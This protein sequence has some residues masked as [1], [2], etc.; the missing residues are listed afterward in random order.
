M[1]LPLVGG[2]RSVGMDGTVILVPLQG[3]R[4][5]K[6]QL[7]DQSQHGAVTLPRNCKRR[8]VPPDEVDRK[9]APPASV[10]RTM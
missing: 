4:G 1:S 2:L 10:L 3:S 9:A 7:T 6:K 8:I 5:E